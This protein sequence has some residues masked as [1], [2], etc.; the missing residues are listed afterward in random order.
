MSEKS[1]DEAF[2]A[3]GIA[4]AIRDE[5][6]EINEP[7]TLRQL[8]MV[9][10]AIAAQIEANIAVYALAMKANPQ[11]IFSDQATEASR[12]IREAADLFSEVGLSLAKDAKLD[13]DDR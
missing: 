11:L 2:D 6:G 13:G 8:A 12:R 5:F 7:A 3:R 9:Y 4:E 10:G 1:D